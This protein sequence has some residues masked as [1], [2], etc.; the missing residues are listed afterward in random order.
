MDDRKAIAKLTDF[1]SK[2]ILH[3]PGGISI[4]RNDDG[5][6]QVF[7]T[8]TLHN[9]EFGCV[10]NSRTN[11][12]SLLFASAKTAITWCI[13]E[14]RNKIQTADRISHLDRM[15]TGIDISIG[16]HRRLIK[17]SKD[18]NS[19]LIYLAKLTEE[20]EKRK[21]MIKELDKYINDSKV[22]QTKKFAERTK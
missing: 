20:Q 16:M 13:F 10:V 2:E 4:F 18:Y 17:K 5:S 7:N 9:D 12:K 14:K 21:H 6:Y 1:F 8:Y 15:I 11:D 19:R 22:W 3:G